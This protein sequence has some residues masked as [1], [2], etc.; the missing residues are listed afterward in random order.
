MRLAKSPKPSKPRP[1]PPP[2]VA[3]LVNT[4]VAIVDDYRDRLAKDRMY[5]VVAQRI[6]AFAAL[7]RDQIAVRDRMIEEL[8]SAKRPKKGGEPCGGK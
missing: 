8:R 3:E 7:L 2:T 4:I 5:A 1:E 6:E